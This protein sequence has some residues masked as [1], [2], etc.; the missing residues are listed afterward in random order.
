MDEVVDLSFTGEDTHSAS[1]YVDV[2]FRKM[3]VA[4]DKDNLLKDPEEPN[5]DEVY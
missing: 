2:F 1:S 3:V 5:W 4:V